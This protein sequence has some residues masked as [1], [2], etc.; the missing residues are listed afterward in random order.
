METQE[1]ALLRELRWQRNKMAKEKSNNDN[2]MEEK[3]QE[4]PK[5]EEKKEENLKVEEKPNAEEKKEENSKSEEKI[6]EKPKAEEKK[7]SKKEVAVAKGL[8]LHASKKHC[9]Y[10]CS[11]IKGKSIDDAILELQK[12]VKM[13]RPIPFKGEIPHRS[14]P[15]MMSGRYPIKA[16]GQ[17]ISVLKALKG[18]VVVNGMDLE[19]TRIVLA[20]S[21]WASRNQKKGGAKFKRTNVILTAKEVNSEKTK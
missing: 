19:K 10:I 12:V 1:L 11:F 21:S 14:Y 13:K 15:N 16:S 6:Q 2:S 20:S 7:I 17:L 4:K 9:M 8:N 18:N 3:I 5:A